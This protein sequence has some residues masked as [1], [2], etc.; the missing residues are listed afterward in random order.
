MLI[1]S[2]IVRK[3]YLS[4]REDIPG[5]HHYVFI[6]FI[7]MRAIYIEIRIFE[8]VPHNLSGDAEAVGDGDVGNDGLPAVVQRLGAVR[9]HILTL[10]QVDVR[11]T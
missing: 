8:N 1:V 4:I 6:M 5:T 9:P 3:A 2:F 10:R 11:G 7:Q